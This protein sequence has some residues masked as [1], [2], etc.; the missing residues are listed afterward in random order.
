M[1]GYYLVH[2]AL[3]PVAFKRQLNLALSEKGDPPLA[4]LEAAMGRAIEGHSVAGAHR[5]PTALTGALND[6]E[7]MN[8]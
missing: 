2:R 7:R 4:D 5:S 3:R 6:Y 1:S 8:K